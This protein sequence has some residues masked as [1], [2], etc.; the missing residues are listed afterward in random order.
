MASGA[1]PQSNPT[2]TKDEPE[3]IEGGDVRPLEDYAY[4]EMRHRA[5]TARILAYVLVGILAA[6]ILLQYGLTTWLVFA[7]RENAAGILD[8]LFN[9]LLPVLAGLVGGAVTFYFTKERN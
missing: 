2:R 1:T 4:E 5:A 6:T 8:K 3:L 7:G 9:A